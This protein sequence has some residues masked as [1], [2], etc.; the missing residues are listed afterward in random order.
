MEFNLTILGSSSATPTENRHHSAFVLRFGNSKFMI[1]C[2]E[3]TQNRCL[4]YGINFQKIEVIFITHM[5]GDHILGLFGMINTMNLFSR[6]K[7]LTIYTI[8]GLNRLIQAHLET[9]DVQL[10]FQLE[11]VELEHAEQ[12]IYQEEHLLVTAFP[13]KH[14]IPCL[15]YKFEEINVERKLNIEKCSELEVPYEAFNDI[16]KGKNYINAVGK[17]IDNKLLTFDPAP[18]HSYVHITDT[19]YFKEI[20]KYTGNA[21]LIYHEATF[22][23]NLEGRATETFHS[24]AKQAA[25]VASHSNVGKLIIGHFSSRYKDL[26]QHLEEAK[27]IFENSFLAIEGDTISLR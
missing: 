4:Q 11:I 5:H 9:S 6:K 17:S 12:I 26:T 19:L 27:A 18:P 7:K 15:A 2:G 24:T 1:D 20:E 14:R 13:V 16:K 22:L 25:Q 3:G 23:A 10:R 8:K 21:D